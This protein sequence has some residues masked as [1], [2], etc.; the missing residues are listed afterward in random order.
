M[1]I[2]FNY[3]CVQMGNA[4]WELYCLEHGFQPDGRIHESSTAS[5][6]DSSFGTFF[7]ET[8]GGK[9]VPRAVFIDLEP[10]VMAVSP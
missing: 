2:K 8:G 3:F 9:Y 7:S 5:L 6:A 10:T 1:D 4:C